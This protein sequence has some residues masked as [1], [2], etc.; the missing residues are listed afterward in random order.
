MMKPLDDLRFSHLVVGVTDMERD[1]DGTA[2]KFI[3]LPGAA[4]TL[5]DMHRGTR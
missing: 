2:V 3:E 4:R 5:E 1:P